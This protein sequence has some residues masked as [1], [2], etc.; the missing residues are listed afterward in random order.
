M[1][2]IISDGGRS[3]YFKGEAGDCVTRA[4][5]NATGKDYLDVYNALNEFGKAE[6]VKHHRGN[7]HS[8]ARTGV[9]KETI[10][11]YLESIGWE[12]VPTMFIGKGCTVHLRTDE[13]PKG[14]LIVNVS[15]HTTCVKDG[16]LYDTE[17]CSRDG[18]RCV[19]GYYIHAAG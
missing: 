14:I 17:D 2:L 1:D 18:A 7:K 4:I 10:R 8:N 3:K 9:F 13:L 6:N 16:I 19:Y 12:W 15:K 5:C 11:S